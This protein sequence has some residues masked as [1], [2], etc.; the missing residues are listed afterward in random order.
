MPSRPAGHGEQR[1]RFAAEAAAVDAERE[2]LVAALAAAGPSASPGSRERIVES[3][4][5]LN[6]RCEE[7]RTVYFPHAVTLSIASG[8]ATTWSASGLMR[9]VW[10]RG[11][12]A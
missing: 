2:R 7:I 5:R 8:T 11:T 1:A 3:L 4:L 12:H 9:T 6:A 10:H